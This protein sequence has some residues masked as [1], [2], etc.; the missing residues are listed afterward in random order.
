MGALLT[1][2]RNK[3]REMGKETPTEL[4]KGGRTHEGLSGC[5]LGKTVLLLDDEQGLTDGEPIKAC[6]TCS[7]PNAYQFKGEIIRQTMTMEL[8]GRLARD[9]QDMEFRG[10]FSAYLR[11]IDRKLQNGLGESVRWGDADTYDHTR[12]IQNQGNRNGEGK[13][14]DSRRTCQVIGIIKGG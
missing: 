2:I 9:E 8:A 7:I 4:D 11:T 1:D 5:S 13:R 6:V 14:N 12:R 3:I 10:G